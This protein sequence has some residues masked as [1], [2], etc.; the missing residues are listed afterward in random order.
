MNV[1]DGS[2]N[3]EEKTVGGIFEYIVRSVPNPKSSYESQSQL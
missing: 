3:E 1:T 2:V